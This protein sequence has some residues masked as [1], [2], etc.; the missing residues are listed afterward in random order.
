MSEGLSAT[1]EV[2]IPESSQFGFCEGVVAADDL[3]KHVSDVALEHGLK[4]FCYHDIVHNKH[5]RASHER[6][7][8]NFVDDL[9][10]VPDGSVVVTS[11]HGIGPEI[12]ARLREKDCLQFDATCPL[13]EH[14]HNGVRLARE[15]DQA[16][17]YICQGKP[18]DADH[19]HD[20]VMGTVGWMDFVYE[21]GRLRYDPVERAYVELSDDLDSILKEVDRLS[22]TVK[23]FRIVSQ[24]TLD[25]SA[26]L[27]LRESIVEKLNSKFLGDK[28]VSFSK[29]G[30][31][32]KAV[33]FRQE[34]VKDNSSQRDPDSV[35]VVTDPTSKNGLGY[36]DIA[37]KIIGPEKVFAVENADDQILS[38]LGGIILVTA[39]ASTP[40]EQTKAV[41]EK[42][43]GEFRNIKRK[44]F[45]LRD[46]K[47][48]EERIL[49][50]IHRAA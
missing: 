31:V 8:V 19:V 36:R 29:P 43:G 40:D 10:L 47:L 2:I 3:L 34:W 50:F 7:G 15:N 46:A 5:V 30:D 39:S 22:S 42:L 14:T 17:V 6:R 26:T 18:G 9:E 1:N 4:I 49:E 13:V 16:V 20:E 38:R 11:A 32:C 37:A 35:V 33:F 41:V 12:V 28:T 45:S 23:G 48:V 24:T 44:S 21:N 25:S 27:K